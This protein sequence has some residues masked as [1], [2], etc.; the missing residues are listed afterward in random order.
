MVLS[1]VDIK[2]IVLNQRPRVQIYILLHY[3]SA[4]KNSKMFRET[5]IVLVC[6][7]HANVNFPTGAVYYSWVNV[8][9]LILFLI[10]VRRVNNL[11]N[12]RA[13]KAEPRVTRSVSFNQNSLFRVKYSFCVN[14]IIYNYF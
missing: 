14:Y 8:H 12:F 1:L 6:F 10:F 9:Q 11:M 13:L 2:K 3:F 7:F 5:S 4:I